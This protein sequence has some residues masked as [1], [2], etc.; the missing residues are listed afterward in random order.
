M[1][2][3]FQTISMAL[4]AMVMALLLVAAPKPAWAQ[5]PGASGATEK[6]TDFTA[7]MEKSK[8]MAEAGST[9]KGLL[10]NISDFIKGVINGASQKLFGAFTSNPN[11][12]AAVGAAM[13][14][15]VVI[16]GVAF[17]I[18]V[19]QPSYGEV[20]KR[21]V[22]IGIIYAIISPSGGWTFFSQYAVRFFNDGTDQLI[23]QVMQ[24]GTGIPF[25]AGDS[26]FKMLDAL[27]AFILSPDMIIAILG[28]VFGSGPY[29]LTVG[30]LLGM[31]V[32]GLLKML[33]D[34]LKTYALS[35]IVRGLL[36]GLAPIFLIFLLF[37]KTKPLFTGWLNALINLSLQPILY[38]TF[39]SFF[40]VMLQA[41]AFDLLGGDYPKTTPAGG[42]CA[43]KTTELC[44]VDFAGTSG[45]ANKKSFWRFKRPCEAF[46]AA[47]ESGWQGPI[48][49]MMNGGKDKDGKP[50]PEF[51]I[52]IIDILSFLILVYVAQRFGDVVQRL[53]NEISSAFVN[54]DVQARM[55]F[56]TN[57]DSAGGMG[58]VTLKG[59]QNPR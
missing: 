34:A 32:M 19:V 37:E 23:G 1:T 15:M 53:A 13:T 43:S 5:V 18:G 12:S 3:T 48:S 22:K 42:T 4:L 21:L 33:L 9:D 47:E 56:K 50:C 51:P 14:L 46:P 24:I 52:N 58:A 44:W 20:L 31:A 8:K 6:C 27:A 45:T 28:A 10:T 17:T 39:I 26:P 54:L 38:F 25:A 35:F 2:G 55:D 11:Y 36:L 29:G 59:G 7:L 40:L 30:A 41:S 57:S 49:C 16:Y